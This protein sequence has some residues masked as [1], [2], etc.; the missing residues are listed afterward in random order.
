M[1]SRAAFIQLLEEIA[2]REELCISFAADKWVVKLQSLSGRSTFIYGYN[3]DIN[4][5]ASQ[6][7]CSRFLHL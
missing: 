1:S 2:E 5:S 7:V 4:G 6:Q 3:F